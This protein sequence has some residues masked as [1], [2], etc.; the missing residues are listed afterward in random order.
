MA[1]IQRLEAKRIALGLRPEVGGQ[2]SCVR[3]EVG[4]QKNRVRFEARGWRQN[5]LGI[6]QIDCGFWILDCGI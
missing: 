1:T 5:K 2:K 3:F 6:R 4:G